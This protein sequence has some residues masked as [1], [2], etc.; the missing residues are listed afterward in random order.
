MTIG[1]KNKLKGR[2]HD[3]DS[4]AAIFAEA[5]DID[6]LESLTQEEIAFAKLMFHRR[7]VYEH[8]GGAADEKYIRDSGDSVQPRQALRESQESA[9][10][11]VAIVQQLA[12]N[13][14]NGFHRIRAIATAA[15][16]VLSRGSIAPWPSAPSA[17]RAKAP[18]LSTNCFLQRKVWT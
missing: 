11:I 7:H 14:H 6:I 8:K 2:F 12:K 4:V 15:L 17:A 10:K 9:H 1:R 5:F 3:L 16:E 13:L 18:K